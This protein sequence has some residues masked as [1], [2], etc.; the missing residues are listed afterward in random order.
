MPCWCPRWSLNGTPTHDWAK[1]MGTKRKELK[2]LNDIHSNM[3]D[4]VLCQAALIFS[5]LCF[6]VLCMRICVSACTCYSSSLGLANFQCHESMQAF[7]TRPNCS[8]FKAHS[9]YAM[10]TSPGMFGTLWAQHIQW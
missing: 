3:L 9:L 10:L 8:I 1:F 6:S 7:L 4:K 5:R 2:R